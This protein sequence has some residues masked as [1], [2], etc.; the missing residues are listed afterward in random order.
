MP[1]LVV[2]ATSRELRAFLPP[3]E[4][5]APADG[6]L[7]GAGL[8]SRALLLGV[9]G[10]GPVAAALRMGRFLEAAPQVRG[11]VN[12]GI[13]GAFDTGRLP[14]GSLTV[15]EREILPEYGR[16]GEDGVRPLN[17]AQAI[18]QGLDVFDSMDLEPALA[19]RAMG[20]V[21]PAGAASVVSLTVAGVSASP[22]RARALR[23]RTGADTE[24]M[25]GFSVALA[26]RERGLP[27][28][29]LRAVSNLVGGCDRA[30]DWDIKA[31]FACLSRLCED[32][33]P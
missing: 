31:A 18:C 16:V 2:A 21:L 20:L 17:F 15:A 7:R 4:A 23:E 19:A 22:G 26:C 30:R 32:L 27:F 28:L 24:N 8:G 13:A 25:E 3:G 33:F 14:L 10:V 9:C 5:D 6:E 11:V 1:I 12:V 29:E